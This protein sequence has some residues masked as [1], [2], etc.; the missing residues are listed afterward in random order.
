[1]VDRS[2]VMRAWCCH[3]PSWT[4]GCGRMHV[5]ATLLSLCKAVVVRSVLSFHKVGCPVLSFHKAGC[6]AWTVSPSGTITAWPGVS[7]SSN[8]TGSSMTGS[9]T[10]TAGSS[11]KAAAQAKGSKGKQRAAKGS[12]GKQAEPGRHLIEVN[13]LS[14]QL[15][16]DVCCLVLPILDLHL[17]PSV[18]NP[19]L[20]GSDH[21]LRCTTRAQSEA[22]LRG[23]A[24]SGALPLLWAVAC[25]LADSVI[26]SM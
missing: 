9:S 21:S 22:L 11:A 17:A 13:V 16:L 7:S 19:L 23:T 20:R 12:K 18:K 25:G 4:A 15:V 2:T 5:R 24:Q 1:M 14:A 3:V 26:L 10:T 8:N 6:T